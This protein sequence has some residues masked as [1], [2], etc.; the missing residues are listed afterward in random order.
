MVFLVV[1]RVLLRCPRWFVRCSKMLLVP[2]VVS[3]FQVV[4]RVCLG[5]YV[6]QGWLWLLR[7]LWWLLR[8]FFRIATGCEGG[9][10]WLPRNDTTLLYLYHV[11]NRGVHK[12]LTT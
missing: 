8:C 10:G 12:L 1:A 3:V 7:Y 11:N 6:I 4:A 9:A 5:S 2:S